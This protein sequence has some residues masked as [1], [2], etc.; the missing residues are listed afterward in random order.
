[1]YTLIHGADQILAESIEKNQLNANV[2]GDGLQ[3]TAEANA[4]SIKL[5]GATLG[6]SASGIKVATGGIGTNEIAANA[7][8]D[9]KL[10]ETKS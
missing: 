10:D 4:I 9:T 3:K 7:V 1:M 6:V 5:E 2:A 8:D